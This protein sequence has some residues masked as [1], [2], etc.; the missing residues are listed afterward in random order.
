V[1]PDTIAGLARI[2]HLEDQLARLPVTSER[3]RQCAIAIRIAGRIYRESRPAGHVSR[4]F[5]ANTGRTSRRR[6]SQVAPAD[7]SIRI[8]E[9]RAADKVLFFEQQRAAALDL[10]GE[11]VIGT[12]LP[13][14]VT[15]LNAVAERLTGWTYGDAM[16]Q[17]LAR[18]FRVIDATT[19]EP[20]PIPTHATCLANV[21]GSQP[22]RLLIQR[23]G[24]ETPIEDSASRIRDRVGQAIG[25]VIVFKDVGEAQATARQAVYLAQHDP[26]TG[27]PNRI[28]LSDRLTQAIA[29]TRRH[30]GHLAVLFLD[31]DR[32]K[33]VNDSLGCVIG[34]T[35][36]QSVAQRLVGCLRTTDTVSRHGDDE[37]VVVL[38]EIEHA[39]DAAATAQ[40]ILAA[41][42]TPHDVAR[43]QL[44]ITATVGIS[45][46]PADG[47]DAETLIKCADTAMHNAKESGR[48]RYQVFEPDMNA[49]AVERQ[50][51]EAG[52]HRAL[53]QHELV[54]HYQPK[55]A[56]D[57]GAMTGVEGLVR[58]MH[59]ERGLMFPKD[60][61]P[62]AE[63]C[64][65]IV[66][67]GR[68]VLREACRQARAWIDEG[69]PPIAVAVN[70]S[71]M[72]FRDPCFVENVR[73][74][75]NET[76]LEARYLELELTESSLVQHRDSTAAVLQALKGMGVQVAIDDFGTG[77]S[78]L[79]YLRQFPVN[80]LKIDQSFVREISADSVGTSIVSAVISMGKSLGHRVVAEGVET[81]QQF[82]F[83]QTERC[84]EGQGY[85]FSRPLVAE[86]L[87]KL[88]DTDR[89]SNLLPF[90]QPITAD[91]L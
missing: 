55:I 61:V 81:S 79:S 56:L 78:G 85:Y 23:D 2:R 58:W 42:A 51:I 73:T 60:F 16:G 13:G 71:A 40:K 46:Y 29:M 15:Y 43:H 82:A 50:W 52:L 48:N 89:I 65:L 86:Q 44:H 69:R 59:P 53:A 66:P 7:R 8:V 90:G 4:Q 74:V 62:I 38:S 22:N 14:N 33:Q 70:V 9:R 47:A 64:G 35:L 21:A 41:L 32:F 37:F 68:W 6:D 49:R 57:T 87:V 77:Y 88:F 45:I 31:L 91:R 3:H 80:V 76:R 28:L 39:D 1:D 24:R 83:L 63:E 30:D 20:A 18:I 34:D 75:L 67:I 11:G 84:G 72:E 36:M 5:D 26:L 19:R 12:D 25:A 10:I 17:P 54:L 27:L